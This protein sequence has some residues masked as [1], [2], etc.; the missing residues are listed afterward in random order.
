MQQKGFD[1]RETVFA[2]DSGNDLPVLASAVP[3]VL[4]ANASEEVREAAVR[5][6][7]ANGYPEALYVARGTLPGMNGN[8]TA[9][10]LE[11]VLHYIPEAARWLEERR[12]AE[13]N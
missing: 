9:G 11:G 10:V 1:V 8:Y 3:A 2:G 7:L 6:A 5:Q 12:V 4:V 13:T